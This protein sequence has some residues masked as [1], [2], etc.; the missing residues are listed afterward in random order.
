MAP[1]TYGDLGKACRDIFNKGYHFG[2]F[3]LD[4]KTTTVGGVDIS[5]GGTH[6]FDQGR[7]FGNLETKYKWPAYGVTLSEKWNTDNVIVT[8]INC[9][10]KLAP[11]VKIGVEGTFSP[12]SG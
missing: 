9:Q 12:A 6:S 10:D 3:K 7:V 5:S 2:L 4:C 11:G 8:E 1:P